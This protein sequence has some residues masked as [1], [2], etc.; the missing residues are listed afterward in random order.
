MTSKLHF[1]K[2]GCLLC[3]QFIVL[4]VKNMTKV[5]LLLLIIRLNY[6][7]YILNNVQ[8]KQGRTGGWKDRCTMPSDTLQPTSSGIYR[9]LQHRH[10]RPQRIHQ[11]FVVPHSCSC[12]MIILTIL[13][14]DQA[15]VFALPMLSSLL[16]L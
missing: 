6:I 5:K 4:L 3:L 9:D 10:C 8:K 12:R 13:G 14:D 7:Q 2:E 16:V 11:I 15:R 1:L